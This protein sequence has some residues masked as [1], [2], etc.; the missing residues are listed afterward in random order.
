MSSLNKFFGNTKSSDQEPYDE[1]TGPNK[2]HD[3]LQEDTLDHLEAYLKQNE[4]SLSDLPKVNSDNS[5]LAYAVD[6]R[7]VSVLLELTRHHCG[8]MKEKGRHYLGGAIPEESNL[9][10]DERKLATRLQA[11][12]VG[13][14][15]RMFDTVENKLNDLGEIQINVDKDVLKDRVKRRTWAKFQIAY[16]G[17]SQISESC[18]KSVNI[19]TA[20]AKSVVENILGGKEPTGKTF[21]DS[22]TALFGILLVLGFAESG[23]NFSAFIL[24]FNDSILTYLIMTV[25]VGVI[26][27]GS[28]HYTGLSIVGRPVKKTLLIASSGF[29]L[30]MLGFIAVIRLK[31]GL[32]GLPFVIIS[33]G[34]WTYGT[35]FSY[36]FF[37]RREYWMVQ[38]KAVEAAENK[39]I[40]D[41]LRVQLKHVV[42][43]SIADFCEAVE[44]DKGITLDTLAKIKERNTAQKTDFIAQV[45]NI[46]LA[47]CE[48]FREAYRNLKSDIYNKGIDDMYDPSWENQPPKFEDVLEAL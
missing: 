27:A 9:T 39:I 13:P 1:N 38:E 30:F 12:V 31:D 6:E 16:D 32:Q 26:L 21:Y 11:D 10:V 19:F 47:G 34:L 23:I 25:A 37:S 18:L 4:V 24:H 2:V 5:F 46:Y 48:D 40:A 36:K 44:D 17:L 33:V 15:I 20:K 43:S 29:A 45:S 3:K 28:A 8:G 22:L 7:D 42:E 41:N 14:G 35:F